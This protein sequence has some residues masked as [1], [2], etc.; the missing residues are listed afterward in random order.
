M[1]RVRVGAQAPNTPIRP[2]TSPGGA[3]ETLLPGAGS[4]SAGEL[5]VDDCACVRAEEPGRRSA[6]LRCSAERVAVRHLS[7]LEFAAAS[8]R[9]L[10]EVRIEGAGEVRTGHRA[11][12]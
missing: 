6:V 7:E 4:G 12:G 2:L 9:G 1:S 3:R 8:N 11:V 5:V 10:R